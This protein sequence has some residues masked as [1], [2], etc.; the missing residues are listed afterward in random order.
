[1][2]RRVFTVSRINRYIRSILEDDIVLRNIFIEGEIS[3]FKAHPSGHVYFS[4]KDEYSQISCV[5]FKA[6]AEELAFRP[7]NGMKAVLFGKISAYEKTG[8]YQFYSEKMEPAGIGALYVKFE[9]LKQKLFAEG[10]FDASRKKPLPAYPKTVAVITS[11]SGAAVMDIINVISRR[12]KTIKIV[13]LPTAVQG[14]AAADEIVKSL[15]KVNEWGEADCVI[16]GRGGGSAEDLQAFNEEK[17]ARAVAASSV[18]VVSAVG[19][20]TDYTITDFTADLRAPT[21]SAAAELVAPALSEIWGGLKSR[22]GRLSGAITERLAETR[23]ALD[24]ISQSDA[25]KNP[26]VPFEKKRADLLATK[27]RLNKEITFT[28]NNSRMELER[29]LDL[30]ESLSRAKILKRGYAY[31]SSGD[32]IYAGIGDI[33]LN[34]NVTINFH[35]GGADARIIKIKTGDIAEE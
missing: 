17:V 4:L 20:E 16:L 9:Q 24:D 3:N 10:L 22:A 14:E 34:Q 25:L 1:M 19:H 11:G 31:V 23:R 12:N 29:R 35:D 15:K 5:M 21:P 7:E 18:P 26:L 2:D 13:V 27:K 8:Q 33:K 6:Y 30:L 32:K 28:L